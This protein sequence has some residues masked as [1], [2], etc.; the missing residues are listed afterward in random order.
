MRFWPAFFGSFHSVRTYVDARLV[1]S[2]YG[3]WYSIQLVLLM[4]LG[5]IMYTAATTPWD[6]VGSEH[7]VDLTKIIMIAIGF[8]AA[9]LIGLTV[10]ARLL[11]LLFSMHL[12]WAQAARLTAISYTPVAVFDAIAFCLAHSAVAPPYLFVCGCL[13]LLAALNAAK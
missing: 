12:T 5:V 4:A 9:M 3:V 13:M 2:G 7:L 8:R 1:L 10:A 6:G 11:A